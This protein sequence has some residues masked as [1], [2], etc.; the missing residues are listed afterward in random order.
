MSLTYHLMWQLLAA[1]NT[2]SSSRRLG[3]VFVFV[4]VRANIGA[5]VVATEKIKVEFQTGF[6]FA[7]CMAAGTTD[8]GVWEFPI[9]TVKF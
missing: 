7:R 2:A 5:F 8:S 9:K 4:A 6:K 1:G 3:L